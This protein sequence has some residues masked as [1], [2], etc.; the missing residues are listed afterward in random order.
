MAKIYKLIDPRNNKVCYVGK[1]VLTLHHRLLVHIYEAKKK[2]TLKGEWIKGLLLLDLK[3]TIELIEEVDDWQKQEKYWIAFYKNANTNIYNICI[4]G[5]IGGVF[6][7]EEK[8]RQVILRQSE[9]KS[10]PVYQIDFDYTVLKLHDSCKKA[11][12]E[13]GVTAANLNISARSSGKKSAGGFLWC[14]PENF[15]SLFRIEGK[16]KIQYDYLKHNVRQ[17]SKT[18]TFIKEWKSLIEAAE[19]LGL[20]ASGISKAK[21]GQ[22]KTYKGFVWK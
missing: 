5:S 11:A 1:T 21:T 18:G 8:Q 4:G 17:F 10:K 20:R 19:S 3:P 6:L 13:I 22:R 12:K 14:Y 7:T 16:Y 9:A 2:S 15:E